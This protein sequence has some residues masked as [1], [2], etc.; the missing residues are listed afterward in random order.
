MIDKLLIG[1]TGYYL[2]KASSDQGDLDIENSL[3]HQQ[4]CL[5]T[6]MELLED[7]QELF[8]LFVSGQVDEKLVIERITNQMNK[9]RTNLKRIDNRLRATKQE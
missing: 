6:E 1:A 4:S 7:F 9:T 3:E 5:A 2:G 8:T